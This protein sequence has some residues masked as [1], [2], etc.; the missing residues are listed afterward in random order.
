MTFGVVMILGTLG[1]SYYGRLDAQKASVQNEAIRIAGLLLD[2]WKAH[3]GSAAYDPATS[4]AELFT[5]SP[6]D[7]GPGGLTNVLKRFDLSHEDKN[8]QIT[9][10]SRPP[11][12]DT[13][14]V[15]NVVVAWVENKAM[16]NSEDPRKYVKLSGYIAQYNN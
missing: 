12:K 4:L 14:K 2:D 8:F 9:I 7:S 13:T 16:L 10:S 11:I 5:L 1:F 15:L 3:G 6:T